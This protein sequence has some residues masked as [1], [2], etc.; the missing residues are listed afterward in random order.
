MRALLTADRNQHFARSRMTR[1]AARGDARGRLPAVH[2]RRRRH[3]PRRRRARA[4]PDPPLRRGRRARAI[5][6]RIR[7]PARRSAATRAARCW[8]PRTSRSS[9]STPRASSSTSWGCPA[10]SSPAPTPRRRRSS[11]AAAT[12]AISRSSSAPPTSSC[13]TYKVGYLAILKSL[14]ELGVDD[15]RGHLLFAV[16]DERVRR[17]RR[18]ARRGRA[19]CALRRGRAPRRCKQADASGDRGAARQGRD[20]LRARPGRPRP[21]SRPTAQAVADVIEFRASEGE[22]FEMSAE[23]WLAF[24]EPR[25]ASTPRARRRGRWASSVIWDCELA[26]DARGLLPGPGRHRVRDRQVARRR[27][28]RR[29]ALDGDEDRRPRTTRGASPRRSTP[30]SRTRCW[31]TTCRRRS[32]GTRPA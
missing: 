29:P 1:G 11:T 8:W 25:V 6:S 16:S 27:A 18:L 28:V 3:R 20:A 13:P 4:Q 15:A 23:E 19:C 22:R 7:S 12:S 10:S 32:T 9:A 21:A 26:E 30:S 24:A 31:P 17:G 5:T 14:R 2:H